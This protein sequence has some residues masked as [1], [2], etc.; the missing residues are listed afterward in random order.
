M[1]QMART[2]FVMIRTTNNEYDRMKNLANAKGFTSVSAFIRNTA[3][4]YGLTIERIIMETNAIVKTIKE[5]LESG[6]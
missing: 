4:E 1:Y 5:M 6:S 3:L 2:K